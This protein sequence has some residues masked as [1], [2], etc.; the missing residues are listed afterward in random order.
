MCSALEL[1]GRGIGLL[2]IPWALH[3]LS[4]F[5]FDSSHSGQSCH[6]HSCDK[7]NEV[8]VGSLGASGGGLGGMSTGA[9]FGVESV[10]GSRVGACTV[11]TQ[12]CLC[13]CSASCMCLAMVLS[14]SK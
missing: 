12:G 10:E 1:L 14:W 4:I 2:N 8:A 3:W 6:F 7:V 5:N 13:S 11:R 9:G